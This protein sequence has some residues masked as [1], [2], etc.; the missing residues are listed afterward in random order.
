MGPFSSRKANLRF[1]TFLKKAPTNI[2]K[3]PEEGVLIGH[4]VDDWENQ[5]EIFIP[6]KKG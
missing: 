6:A 2:H 5:K 3:I 4:I 1:Q